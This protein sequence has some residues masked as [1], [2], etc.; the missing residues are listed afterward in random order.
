MD[1]V[2]IVIAALLLFG[3]L[4]LARFGWRIWRGNEE[5]QPGGS[6]GRQLGKRE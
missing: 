4:G 5:M 6:M 2:V 1:P 3:L